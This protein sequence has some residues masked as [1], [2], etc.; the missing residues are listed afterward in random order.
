MPAKTSYVDVAS[1]IFSEL[2]RIKRFSE[3]V[4]NMAS[5]DRECDEQFLVSAL[6]AVKQRVNSGIRPKKHLHKQLSLVDKPHPGSVWE[7]ITPIDTA[8]A[9]AQ[10]LDLDSEDDLQKLAK[11]LEDYIMVVVHVTADD[12]LLINS[13]YK[14]SKNEMPPGWQFGDCRFE[15][16]KCLAPEK[17][18]D[19]K[20]QWN[21]IVTNAT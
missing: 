7:H 15:R 12:N 10:T 20:L 16:Y 5:R 1:T 4:R 18:E 8:W 9:Y 6:T 17:I 21:R 11:I 19:L 13:H 14:N 2:K 3:D